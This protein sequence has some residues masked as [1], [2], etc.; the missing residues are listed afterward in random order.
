M[1]S[2]IALN[3]LQ[4]TTCGKD[5]RILIVNFHWNSQSGLEGHALDNWELISL[6]LH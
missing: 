5:F 4:Y 6:E 3:G 1:M 2:Y